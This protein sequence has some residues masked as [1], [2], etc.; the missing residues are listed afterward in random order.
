M[1]QT[2]APITKNEQAYWVRLK[3]GSL[4]L[5]QF[6]PFPTRTEANDFCTKAREHMCRVEADLINLANRGRI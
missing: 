6:G 3:L 1:P 4:G 5:Q 2:T